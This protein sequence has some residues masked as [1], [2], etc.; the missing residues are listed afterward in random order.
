MAEGVDVVESA[1][2]PGPE[3][4]DEL[5]R[6]RRIL[7]GLLIIAVLA[8]V[9]FARAVLLPIVLAVVLALTLRPVARGLNRLGLPHPLAAVLI[10]A[11]IAG[12]TAAAIYGASGPVSRLVEQAP[13]I[14]AE[15]RWK[16][17]DL[18]ASMDRV[19]EASQQVEDLAGGGAAQDGAQKV[20]LAQGGLIGTVVGSLASAGTS[21]A[22]AFVLATF[23]LA[24]G[25]FFQRRIVE[26]APR[27]TDKKRALT[28][29]K[30]VERQISTYLAAITVI[31]ACLG[32]AVAVVLGALGLP[33]APLWGLATFLL[34]FLPFIG[35]AVG[36]VAVTAASIIAFDSF[37][38]AILC[39]LAFLALTSI[40]G[41][42]ITP[43]LVGRRL[44]IN[45]IAVLVT[46]LVWGWLWGVAGT[47]L[48]VPVLV[49]V[50]A[51]SDNVGSLETLNRFLTPDDP[52]REPTEA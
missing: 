40:E 6:I 29:V 42:V 44:A 27:L 37:G 3:A 21:L 14:G 25:D 51:I 52:P 9:F 41:Q 12:I 17:R 1:E 32:L 8:T 24:S 11:V 43:A 48:A 2:V 20:V 35:A 30:D 13:Q 31:N 49:I 36:T 19:Q 39:P 33:N 23:L 38:Q 28:I 16:L 26:S 10:V 18:L 4:A 50:K 47:F 22:V 7:T 15:V 45:S 46:L 34:N 5:R